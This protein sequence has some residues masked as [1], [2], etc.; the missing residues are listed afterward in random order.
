VVRTSNSPWSLF[1]WTHPGSKFYVILLCLDMTMHHVSLSA[2]NKKFLTD[3]NRFFCS[4]IF[5]MKTNFVKFC[6]IRYEVYAIWRSANRSQPEMWNVGLTFLPTSPFYFS[7]PSLLFLSLIFS[8][9]L[10]IFSLFLPS[11]PLEVEPL[12]SSWGLEKCCKLPQ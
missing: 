9:P 10:P 4:E 3:S 7:S 1:Q 2:C 5:T 8:L 12:N 6:R 11:L